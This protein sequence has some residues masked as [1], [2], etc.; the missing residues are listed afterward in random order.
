M[1][2]GNMFSTL[3]LTSILNGISKTLNVANQLIPIYQKA[4]PMINN[5]RKI[6][7]AINSIKSNDDIE[8]KQVIKGIKKTDNDNLPVFFS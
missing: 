3:S 7:G 4:K 8:E 2:P 6:L 1:Y 5:S